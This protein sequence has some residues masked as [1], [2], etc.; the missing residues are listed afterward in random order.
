MALD[1]DGIHVNLKPIK[2][3]PNLNLVNEFGAAV[4]AAEWFRE[5]EYRMDRE[6]ARVART[7]WVTQLE[8]QCASAWKE[9]VACAARRPANAGS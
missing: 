5:F 9:R 4:D 6:R 3:L 8:M 2:G 1:L 7:H